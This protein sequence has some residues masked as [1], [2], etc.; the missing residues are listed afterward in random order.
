MDLTKDVTSSVTNN[1]AKVMQRWYSVNK[2][3]PWPSV[4]SHLSCCDDT[5]CFEVDT[6]KYKYLFMCDHCF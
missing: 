4:V 1:R 5:K 2:N 3:D 6:L